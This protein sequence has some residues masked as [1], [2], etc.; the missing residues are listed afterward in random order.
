MP[1]CAQM[2]AQA[3]AGLPS[4]ATAAARLPPVHVDEDDKR[5][6]IIADVPGLAKDDI[7]ARRRRMLKALDCLCWVSGKCNDRAEGADIQHSGR[8]RVSH[9]AWLFFARECAVWL[10][11]ACACTT[12]RQNDACE[13]HVLKLPVPYVHSDSR[14]TLKH[15]S[16][17]SQLTHLALGWV[18]DSNLDC[19]N[20]P[21]QWFGAT[22]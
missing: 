2:H 12:P 18:S 15:A 14:Q 10:G 9:L 3:L 8:Q 1:Q 16:G 7:K 21:T 20:A 5:F 4:L 13:L 11:H 17:L 6:T 19:H 22:Q